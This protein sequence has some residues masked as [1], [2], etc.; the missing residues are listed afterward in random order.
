MGTTAGVGYS[1][2]RNPAE[3]GKE[4][5]RKALEQAKTAKP[6][7]VFVFATV[8][9]D[10]QVLIRS[11]R[12]ATTG[13]PL[14]GCS[15]EGI[16]TQGLADETNF[17]VAVMAIRSDELQF[18]HARVKDFG[19]GADIAG[20]RL[21]EDI[22]P[23]L[24]E[25]S[26]ACFLFPDG[27]SFNFD[28]FLAAFEKS[29]QRKSALPLF[30]G[31]ASDNWTAQ[32]TYQYHDDE[33]FSGGLSLVVLSGNSNVAW[34]VNHG[35]VPAGNSRTVTKSKGNVI[36][37]IDGVPALEALKEYSDEDLNDQWNKASLNLC[38]GFKTPEQIKQS[39]GDYIIRY[40]SAR[41]AQEGSVT[42]Q[43]DVREGADL[44]IVR[45]D[46]ELI[47]SGSKEIS[48]RIQAQ[49]GTKKPKFILHFEC[50][51][52]GKVVFRDSEKLELIRSLQKDLGEDIPWLGFYTYGEI[53]PIEEYNCFH[54]FTAVVAA[55]Y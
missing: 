8:G 52:R 12:E 51:G 46:K 15:G 34:G 5:A 44:W 16:I 50:V 23:F 11:I 19:L 29:L 25:K 31:L 49:V 7:F 2:Q 33:V 36:F 10:Q 38:L 21:A 41:N 42:I 55:V 26:I 35:C 37:E 32:K 4:A 27:L 17:G 43:S 6:D 13:A 53:G 18:Y 54:N 48:R 3:A 30:G 1:V 22:K 9:Y 47:R 28:P 20:L 39:Y 24:S 14:S 45:R 40:M